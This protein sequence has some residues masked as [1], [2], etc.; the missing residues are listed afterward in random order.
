M[1]FHLSPN[2]LGSRLRSTYLLLDRP[3]REG[4]YTA[5]SCRMRAASYKAW[6]VR[7][8]GLSEKVQ[9]KTDLRQPSV[10]VQMV[11]LRG[12]K[13]RQDELFLDFRDQGLALALPSKRSSDYVLPSLFLNETEVW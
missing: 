4:I 9:A 8:A 7:H 11:K 12:G 6:M 5:S 1:R 3:I 2:I 10:I 13:I